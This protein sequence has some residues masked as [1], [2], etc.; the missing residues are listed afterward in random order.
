[1]KLFGWQHKA[2]AVLMSVDN[3]GQVRLYVGRGPGIAG[4]GGQNLETTRISTI[5]DL[6][7]W[8]DSPHKN[9]VDTT[10]ALLAVIQAAIKDA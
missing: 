4:A 3:T 7:P 1:M 6:L 2:I 8:A 5:Q 10:N 9:D